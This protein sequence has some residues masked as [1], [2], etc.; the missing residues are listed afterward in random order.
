MGDGD[1]EPLP[2]ALPRGG[3]A[4]SRPDPDYPDYRG[5]QDKSPVF[6][7]LGFTAQAR[8]EKCLDQ[9]H[10]RVEAE[11][12]CPTAAGRRRARAWWF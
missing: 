4:R 12:R 8:G 6:G 1:G 7:G 11:A 2:E 9:A 3:L 10:C 5:S